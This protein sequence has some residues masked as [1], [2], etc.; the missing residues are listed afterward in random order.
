LSAIVAARLAG[1]DPAPVETVACLYT[2][3]PTRDF[4]I[5]RH[6]EYPQIVVGAGFSGRGF[7]FGVGMGRLLADLTFSPP[8]D[9]SSPFWLDAFRLTRFRDAAAHLPAAD[10]FH[11]PSR[12]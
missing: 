12:P 8:G 3:T 4:V 2:E 6:P 7:K 10:L 9:Y 1:V 11:H 5:D